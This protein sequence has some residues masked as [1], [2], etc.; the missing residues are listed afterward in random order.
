MSRHESKGLNFWYTNVTS[1]SNK[2]D[3]LRIL[4]AD[5]SFDVMM[6]SETWFRIESDTNL[7]GYTLFRKDRPSGHGG[8]CIYVKDE[9]HTSSCFFWNLFRRASDNLV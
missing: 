9:F 3:E 4:V 8:V 1:L 6:I 5:E 2:I 7:K